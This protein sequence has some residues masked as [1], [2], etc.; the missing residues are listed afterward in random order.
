MVYLITFCCY[1]SRVPGEPNVVH[2]HDN[3]FGSPIMPEDPALAAAARRTLA[4]APYL[5]GA[6]ERQAVLDAI[7]EVCRYRSWPLLAAHVRT[8]HV[9]V[10]VRTDCPP[11]RAMNAFKSYASRALNREDQ[12]ATGVRRWARHGSCLLYTSPSPRDS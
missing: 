7:I 10:V 9:H 6:L 5:M 8:T 1:G 12:E 2:R 3:H 4:N 11:E